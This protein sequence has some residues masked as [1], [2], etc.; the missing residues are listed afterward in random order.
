MVSRRRFLAGA[1]AAL[2]SA[3][4]HAESL[5]NTTPGVLRT[6]VIGA[7]M[8]GLYSA[9]RLVNAGHPSADIA[10][11]EGSARIG[12]RLRSEAMPGTEN[13]VAEFGG[14]RY[15]TSQKLVSALIR[16]LALDNRNFPMGGPENLSFIRGKR[17]T[18]ADYG[19]KGALPFDLPP[20]EAGLDPTGLMVRAIER[21]VPGAAKLT[22]EQWP[23]IQRTA[24][25]DGRPLHA[26]GYRDVMNRFLS[27]EASMLVRMGGGYNSIP[28]NWSASEAMPWLL[29][30]FANNPSYLTLVNG[31]QTL[32]T[33][34]GRLVDG[35]GV[36]LN[37]EHRLV[38]LRLDLQVGGLHELVFETPAGMRTIHAQRVILG[39]PRRALDLIEDAPILR[40]RAVAPLLTTVTPRALAKAFVAHETPYWR[41]LG[42][43]SGKATTDM[44]ARQFFYFGTEPGRPVPPKGCLSMAYFDG[45]AADF[46]D[47]Q[48]QLESPGARGFTR[49][50]PTGP[51]AR[52]MQ[53]Q[54]AAVH[55]LPTPP[56]VLSAG[57]MNWGDD[58]YG[59][60]WHSW[61]QGEKSWEVMDRII[62]PLPGSGVH[63]VGE[64][65][66][67]GQGWIE[68]AL[69]TAENLLTTRLGVPRAN[70]L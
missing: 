33:T 65:W 47:G 24:M 29:A 17:W 43:S 25:L 21:V 38:A 1:S 20:D 8:S 9:W 49:L 68:G 11:F 51:F 50:D 6:A 32:P 12:G 70:W 52:E 37:M 36:K 39:L 40:H 30:D 4:I 22:P 27:Y 5:A 15:L 45:D 54:I 16:H 63:I 67:T 58:P 48:R 19:R 44:P 56:P 10:I 42:L 41:A 66:S 23:P 13:I 2:S 46:W 55:A 3:A 35:Q 64:A 59:G 34:L 14:M 18:E 57:Y 28:T 62:D 31:M 61:N 26:W 60:G 7:G 69:Q 53:R